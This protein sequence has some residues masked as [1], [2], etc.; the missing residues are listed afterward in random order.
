MMG[1]G[2][3]NHPRTLIAGLRFDI[4]LPCQTPFISLLRDS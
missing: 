4:V 1:E 2:V 3:G